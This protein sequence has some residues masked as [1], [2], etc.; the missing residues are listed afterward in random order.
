[1]NIL[2][3]LCVFPM[4]MGMKDSGAGEWI[5]NMIF[6]DASGWAMGKVIVLSVI[7]AFL[8]NLFIPSGSAN[9]ALSA[10]V[11]GPILV[12]VGMPVPAAMVMIGVQAGTDFLFPLEGTWQYT[13]GTGHY[14]FSD[15]SKCN[16]PVAL[17]GMLCS[18]VLISILAAAY[19]LFV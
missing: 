9:A 15:C 12:G 5:A 2:I 17:V 4:A 16:W 7:T 1:M 19:G 11:I 13:F 8:V 3:M 18:A 14:S 10:A 6:A